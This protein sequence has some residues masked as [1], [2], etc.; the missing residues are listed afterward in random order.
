MS[1][2]QKMPWQAPD[3]DRN[4]TMLPDSELSPAT[5]TTVLVT[6]ASGLLGSRVALGLLRRG[7]SVRAFQR[8]DADAVKQRLGQQGLQRFSQ[9]RGSLTDPAAVRTALEAADAVV[10]LAA[11][12]SVSG[13]WEEYEAVNIR[14]TRILLE[15]ARQ[16]GVTD[17]LHTSSPS[18]SHAGEPLMGQA[19][20]PADPHRARGNYAVS[21]AWAE[22]MALESDAEDFRVAVLR[23]HLVWGPGDTQLTERV[24]A[25][26]AAGRLPLLGH[27]AALVDSL[28]VDNAAEAFVRALDRMPQ[29]HGRPLVL[30]NGEPRTIGE[31]MGQ[32]CRA[33]GVTE[34]RGTVPASAARTAGQVIEK[35]WEIR[36]GEDEPPM[37]RFLAEQLSTAHWFDQRET[38]R[39]L[40][41]R[42]SVSIDEGM[43][44]LQE[45]YGR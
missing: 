20:Q 42:P 30:T 28:Y 36:P 12:V 35:A 10:H 45:H 24:I 25:R 38:H 19:N 18:V 27:G 1:S 26:A 5:G 16:A 2:S 4:R 8:G 22:R 21:K 31:L 40:D 7:H 37:T 3:A 13:P 9:Y 34:P 43:A 44:R 17:V 14:G 39:L 15:S 33:A 41:W 32:M 29:I 6:G 23:P 11:K